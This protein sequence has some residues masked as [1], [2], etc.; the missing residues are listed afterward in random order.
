MRESA[1]YRQF[2]E[3]KTNKIRTFLATDRNTPSV[4]NILNYDIR[5]RIKLKN[6]TAAAPYVMQIIYVIKASESTIYFRF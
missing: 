6:L 2:R 5:H 3:T 4:Q 1:K